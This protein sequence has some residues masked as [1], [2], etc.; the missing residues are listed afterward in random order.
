M[1]TSF[2]NITNQPTTTSRSKTS[3]DMEEA[4]GIEFGSLHEEF[5]E[6]GKRYKGSNDHKTHFLHKI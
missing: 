4:M 2:N 5:E 3:Q 6:E 1:M